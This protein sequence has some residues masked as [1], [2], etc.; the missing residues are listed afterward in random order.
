LERGAGSVDKKLKDSRAWLLGAYTFLLV[1]GLAF[2]VL[3]FTNR[4]PV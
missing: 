3:F 1:W 2:L 4:L